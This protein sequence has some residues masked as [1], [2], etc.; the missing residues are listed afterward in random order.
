MEDNQKETVLITGANGFVGSRLCRRLMADGFQVI[1]GIRRG[2]DMSLIDDIDLDCRYGDITK[3]ETLPD[4]V[5]DIDYIIHNAGLVKAQRPEQFYKVNQ[6]GA[7]NLLQ[8]ALEDKKLRK[9]IYISSVAAAGPSTAGNPLTED[10]PPRPITEYGRSKVAGEKEVLGFSDKIPV[11]IIRPSAVYG[12]GDQ[13]AFTFFQ[14]LDNRIKPYIGNL[15]RR[16]QMVHVDDLCL[17]ISLALRSQTKT[18]SIYFIAESQAYS[19]RDLIKNIRKAT[20]KVALPMYVPGWGVRIIAAISENIVRAFGK[21]PMF[22]V[23][24]ANEILSNWEISTARAEKELGYH[25]QIPFE[26]GAHETY[27]WYREEGWL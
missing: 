3:A 7:K 4:M 20:G 14:I 10:Q 16:I 2:C 19:Y 1:A 25:S 15:S 13:E 23:E 8:V 12:P 24:K 18:G 9:F 5:K 22:T 26:R 11:V 6:I 21:S 27:L 17:G